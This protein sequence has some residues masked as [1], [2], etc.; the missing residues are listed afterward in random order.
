MN[1]H[2]GYLGN[3]KEV[4][5]FSININPIGLS[6]E[7]KKAIVE[8][9]DDVH[10]YPEID[11]KTAKHCILEYETTHIERLI[12]GNG[13]TELIYLQNLQSI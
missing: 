6:Q 7:V 9:L 4:I 10:R 13:A 12:L 11:G 1:K 2:G 3:K 5:D 8:S